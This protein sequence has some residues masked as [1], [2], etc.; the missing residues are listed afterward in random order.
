MPDESAS[1]ILA[2]IEANPWYHR[3]LGAGQTAVALFGVNNSVKAVLPTARNA[4]VSQQMRQH[5]TPIKRVAASIFT[6]EKVR[7]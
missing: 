2:N 1:A 3:S 4:L 5:V 7:L 6:S